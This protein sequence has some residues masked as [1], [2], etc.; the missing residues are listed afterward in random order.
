MAPTLTRTNAESAPNSLYSFSLKGLLQTALI[1]F[2]IFFVVKT[3]WLYS[4]RVGGKELIEGK[5]EKDL[6]QRRNY[7]VRKVIKER[8][9]VKSTPQLLDPTFQGEWAI[10][11][12]SMTALALTNMAFKDPALYGKEHKKLVGKL[13]KMAQI[14]EIQEFD[15]R[16]WNEKP[17]NALKAF[18]KGKEAKGHVGYV[19]HLGIIVA[20]HYALGGKENLELF[21]LIANYSRSLL[22]QSPHML[23]ET[24]PGECYIPDNVVLVAVI[25]LYDELVQGEKKP[26]SFTKQWVAKM[27]K[28]FIDKKSGLMAFTVSAKGKVIQGGR[29]SSGGW[30]SHYL[31][32][33]HPEFAK[34]LYLNLEK[35]FYDKLFFGIAGMREWPHGVDKEGDVDSGPLIFGL[36]PSGTGFSIAGA[37]FIRRETVLD[38]LLFTSEAAGFTFLWRKERSYLL[39]PLVGEAIMLAMKTVRLWD[40]RFIH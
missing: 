23:S 13:V 3:V 29:G 20:S 5:A 22:M 25:S 4:L 30:N 26:T 38:A 34:E 19:G 39:A 11:T 27:K 12:Y 24:Y 10:V 35:N 37:L 16:L 2:L 6:Q 8:A 1:L 36:S 32:H 21:R 14:D 40:K 33:A 15:T 17:M 18:K 31:L 7:L 9:S 28:E